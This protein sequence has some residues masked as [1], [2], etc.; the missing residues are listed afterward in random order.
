MDTIFTITVM[1]DDLKGIRTWGWFRTREE[2][3]KL[4]LNNVTDLFELYYRYAVVCEVEPGILGNTVS[5]TW[6]HA[7]YKNRR[8]PNDPTVSECEKPEKW[9]GIVGFGLGG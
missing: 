5:E 6:F 3:H 9:A 8:G 7:D 2:A 1:T 4:V